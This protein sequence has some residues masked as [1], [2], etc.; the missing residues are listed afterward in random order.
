MKLNLQL[1]LVQPLRT[2]SWNGH[3]YTAFCMTYDISKHSGD[4]ILLLN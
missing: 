4:A 3:Q 1:I 2:N